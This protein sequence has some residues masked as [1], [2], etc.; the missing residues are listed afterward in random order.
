VTN[1]PPYERG[2]LDWWSSPSTDAERYADHVLRLAWLRG[3]AWLMFALEAGELD[4]DQS[5]TCRL[6]SDADLGL[7]AAQLLD[8]ADI[9]QHRSD[10]PGSESLG[11]EVPDSEMDR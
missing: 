2:E 3:A 8:H 7:V 1:P 6:C 9:I 10:Y 4:T 11:D 5:R